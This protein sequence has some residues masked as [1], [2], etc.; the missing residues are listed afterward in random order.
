MTDRQTDND[1]HSSL[2][3]L[4]YCQQEVLFYPVHKTSN[5]NCHNGLRPIA[6]DSYLWKT[7]L[8]RE[9]IPALR[10]V[11][12][13]KNRARCQSSFVRR[14]SPTPSAYTA[15]VTATNTIKPINHSIGGAPC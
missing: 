13:N 4:L 15:P 14:I 5:G 9:Q 10:P 2:P 3:F 11:I 6:V 1:S 12:E 7:G 8:R